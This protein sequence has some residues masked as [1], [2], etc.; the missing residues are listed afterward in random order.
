MLTRYN[1]IDTLSNE[2]VETVN[3]IEEAWQVIEVYSTQSEHRQLI[4]KEEEYSTVRGLGGDRF[5]LSLG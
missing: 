3:S 4:I 5:T 2:V 1:I